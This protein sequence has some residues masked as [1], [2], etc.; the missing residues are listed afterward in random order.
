MERNVNNRKKKPFSD[1][2]QLAFDPLGTMRGMRLPRTLVVGS[3]AGTGGGA[4]KA[5]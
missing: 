5:E 1:H 3:G 2:F 4:M